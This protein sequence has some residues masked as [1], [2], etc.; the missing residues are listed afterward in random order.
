MKLSVVV[1]LYN[2]FDIVQRCLRSIYDN[3]VPDMEVLLVDNSDKKGVDV[4]LEKFSRISYIK[5]RT[6]I[7]F[8]RAVNVGFAHAKGEFILVLTPDTKLLPNTI[9]QTLDYIQS[10]PKV[11]LVGC[12]F[13]SHPKQLHES[14]FH[15]FPNL[16]SHLYEYNTIFYKLWKKFASREHPIMYSL[17][18]H[19]KELR[20]Q[21]MIGVYMLLR[22]KAGRQVGFLDMQ[23]RMYR[24][25][26]DLCKKLQNA[27]WEIAY[28]PVGGIVHYG[29]ATWKT[30]TF[31]QASDHY[32]R[33]TY[34]FFKKYYGFFYALL[35]YILGLLSAVMCIPV[36]FL[37][38]V[39]RKLQ[40]KD[41]QSSILLPSWIKILRWHISDGLGVI[42]SN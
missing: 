18:E 24:E 1:V 23:F 3:Q 16:T 40:K 8:A 28:L 33:S 7:G 12:R 42:F 32:M 26:T 13:Y 35:A 19:K 39:T 2:E 14:A 31:T 37:T 29:G 6:N 10:H 25:E 38:V 21:H 11:A 17:E 34:L 41:S 27:G 15:T 22:K 9:K 36:L 4:V 30:F 5:N 20:P